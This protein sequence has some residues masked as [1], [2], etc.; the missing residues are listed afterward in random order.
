VPASSVPGRLQT[1][2]QS[3]SVLVS[4]DYASST[5]SS[6]CA[7]YAELSIDSDRGGDETGSSV[8]R[9]RSARSQSPFK[10]SRRA[11]MG[12][13]ADLPQRSSS[14]LKR[15]ASSMEPDLDAN[16]GDEVD[17]VPTQ[18]PDT[19]ESTSGSS[20]SDLPRAMSVDVEPVADYAADSMDG[21]NGT[22][23]KE[24][25]AAR[26][27]QD[28][29]ACPTLTCR[30]D[31][32]SLEEQI[33]TI[34][35]LYEAHRQ[36]P[37]RA[38]EIVYIVA[39]SWVDKALALG[40]DPTHTK[41]AIFDGPLGPVDNSDIIE[42]IFLDQ[43]GAP[44]VRLKQHITM[45]DYEIFPIDAWDLVV[46]WYGIKE[47][48]YAIRRQVVNTAPDPVTAP[49][50]TVETNPLVL[51]IHRTWSETSPIPIDAAL[52][53]DNPPAMKFVVGRTYPMQ[54]FLKD[55]KN[56][57][58]IPMSR[59]IRLWRISI[60]PP[61]PEMPIA[62]KA[63]TPP[64][65]PGRDGDGDDADDMWTKFLINIQTLTSVRK[66]EERVLVDCKD[67]TYSEN[68]NGR[69][70][71]QIYNLTEDVH[72]VVDEQIDSQSFVTTYVQGTSKSKAMITR[73]T[74]SQG[75]TRAAQRL[76]GRRPVADLNR[77]RLEEALVPSDCRILATL[78]T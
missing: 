64:D 27:S 47:G 75:N 11:I 60:Q 20:N 48:Q 38:D 17:L 39:R 28:C 55:L 15:R 8:L 23:D 2:V 74:E 18:P 61:G 68:Y 9:R 73:G 4:A 57:L 33:K 43:H 26:Q 37:L 31:V 63:L 54:A 10:V 66:N 1:L 51:T 44:F 78:A 56:Y 50:I 58:K 76:K 40:G 41:K 5:A 24:G 65:S 19:Q 46:E 42:Q 53:R 34:R 70:N 45:E 67:E 35:T 6:P 13:D 36:T 7:A 22:V 71:L 69:S 59:K 14:P 3:S 21:I 12:G 30:A 62:P 77:R 49:N 29:L 16:M 72:L 52:K 32:P 25:K